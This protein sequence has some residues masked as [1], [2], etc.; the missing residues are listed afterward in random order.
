MPFF[1]G[2]RFFFFVGRFACLRLRRMYRRVANG[3][4]FN[5]RRCKYLLLKIQTGENMLMTI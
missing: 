1:R 5:Y 4:F 3:I 2:L